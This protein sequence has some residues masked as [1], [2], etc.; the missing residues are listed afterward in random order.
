MFSMNHKSINLYVQSECQMAKSKNQ[1]VG[2]PLHVMN[3]G[4]RHSSA[5]RRSHSP[6]PLSSPK[7][8]L[9]QK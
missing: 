2:N 7:E 5:A 9:I 8:A 6:K 4:E 3:L 1:R